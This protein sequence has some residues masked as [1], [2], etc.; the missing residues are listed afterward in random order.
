MHLTQKSVAARCR[1]L[2]NSATR[3]DN[4][5]EMPKTQGHQPLQ[6]LG[7]EAITCHGDPACPRLYGPLLGLLSAATPR[8]CQ[9]QGKAL[10]RPLEVLHN[11]FG[12]CWRTQKCRNVCI[13]HAFFEGQ[14]AWETCARIS[15]S[16]T[17]KEIR[18]QYP[19][20]YWVLMAHL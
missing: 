20:V 1:S 14:K 8:P 9:I 2:S 5:T 10:A 11:T 4:D 16:R 19:F 12:Y 18:Q 3:K 7:A 15:T 13:P 17:S 6:H